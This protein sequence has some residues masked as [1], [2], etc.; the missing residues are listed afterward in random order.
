MKKESKIMSFDSF[1]NESKGA[2]DLEQMG[3][4]DLGVEGKLDD[5]DLIITYPEDWTRKQAIDAINR[6]VEKLNTIDIPSAKVLSTRR[7][8]ILPYIELY[9]DM[10]ENYEYENFT[11]SDMEDVKEYWNDG[12]KDMY[13]E[14]K[15]EAIE[16]IAQETMLGVDTVRQII[17]T[18]LKSNQISEVDE[19]GYEAEDCEDC[20]ASMDEDGIEY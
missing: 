20:R 15:E 5:D 3:F 10:S 12:A 18:M 8:G 6:D 17:S 7:Q 11:I 1:V 4:W 2:I 13:S 19:P 14:N 9:P 16:F